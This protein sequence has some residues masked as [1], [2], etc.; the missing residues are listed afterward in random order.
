MIEIS[1]IG[2]SNWNWK[3]RCTLLLKKKNTFTKKKLLE[4]EKKRKK[5]IKVSFSLY[6][7][8]ANNIIK[9]SN[10]IH[11]VFCFAPCSSNVVSGNIYLKSMFLGQNVFNNHLYRH[12]NWSL[13]SM[14]TGIDKKDGKIKRIGLGH[15]LNLT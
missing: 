12:F 6:E 13:R 8:F 3:L 1:W 9:K 11:F 15:I 4:K 14:I 2:L 5:K 10:S 7:V